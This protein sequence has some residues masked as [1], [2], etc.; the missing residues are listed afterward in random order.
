MS[1]L[2]LKSLLSVLL[3]FLSG[4]A[5]FTMF[6]V[7]GRAEKRFNIENLKRLHKANG[8]IYLSVFVFVS[9]FCLRFII[10]SGS[11]LT[12]RATFHAVFALTILVLFGLKVVFIHIY[13]QFYG[14]VKTIGIL[15]ALI[16]FGMVG[17]SGGYYLLVSKFGTDKAFDKRMQYKMEKRSQPVNADTKKITIRTDTESIAKGKKIYESECTTCH[18]PDSTEWYFGPGHKGILKNPI[19]P[20][21]KKPATPEN[22]AN[23]LRNPFKD[24]PSFS[25][26]SE[27][28][29]LN[30]IAY[31]NTL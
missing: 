20:V 23:Q 29:I 1:I 27:E 30:L 3:L 6:E 28:D 24:M 18:L 16:T 21:S 17:T 2:L 10:I 19:L 12:P 7:F 8:V 13:R 26:L 22:V 4:F 11:E 31:L 9:Y 15:I 5:M 14:G 25:Y